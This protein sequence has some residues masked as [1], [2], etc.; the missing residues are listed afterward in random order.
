MSVSVL[1]EK[2]MLDSQLCEK[3]E[4]G[5]LQ[6]QCSCII[7]ISIENSLPVWLVILKKLQSWFYCSP[8]CFSHALCDRHGEKKKP[9]LGKGAELKQLRFFFQAEN[10]VAVTL[11][12]SSE[13]PGTHTEGVLCSPGVA[14]GLCEGASNATFS[15]TTGC[16]RVKKQK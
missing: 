2:N 12:C 7:K 5:H 14:L 4:A 6:Y 11:W 8:K 13:A 10:W 9:S 1:L 16:I 15:G 3:G